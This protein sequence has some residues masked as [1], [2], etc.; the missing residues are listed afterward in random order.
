M[1]YYLKG[2]SIEDDVADVLTNAGF[3]L[4]KTQA[5]RT[6][7]IRDGKRIFDHA[8]DEEFSVFFNTFVFPRKN[9]KGTAIEDKLAE[10]RRS[11]KQDLDDKAIAENIA[12]GEN[13]T[14]LGNDAETQVTIR[15][16][17]LFQVPIGEVPGNLL[18]DL[19]QEKFLAH[20]HKVKSKRLKR[21]SNRLTKKQV[22]QLVDELRS[23]H[24]QAK[25]YP[26]ANLNLGEAFLLL[27]I[28]ANEFAEVNQSNNQES[29][30]FE[31]ASP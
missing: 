2:Q 17:R 15:S 6:V 25:I 24:A 3:T 10:V 21:K 26:H 14:T 22:G 29:D 16:L 9:G 4:V 8:T 1:F 19:A 27:G 12:K 18:I 23:W 5:G 7:G 30:I 13:V 31:S 28:A 11:K 20:T